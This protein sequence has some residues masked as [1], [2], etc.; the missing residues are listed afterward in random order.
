PGTSS[1]PMPPSRGRA[2][3]PSRPPGIYRL[4][5]LPL[6]TGQS[7]PLPSQFPDLLRR[8]AMPGINLATPQDII[9][10]V[11]Y[12]LG[13]HPDDSLVVIAITARRVFVIVRYDLP[14]SVAAG[15]RDL[16]GE[17]ADRLA[18]VLAQHKADSVM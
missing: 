2:G 3:R 10:A 8:S 4:S 14:D 6:Q 16:A 12:L 5:I 17:L 15:E 9:A 7:E 18:V 11:P 1:Q 13:F